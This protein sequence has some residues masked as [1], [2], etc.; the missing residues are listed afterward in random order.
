MTPV[1]ALPDSSRCPRQHPGA[2]LVGLLTPGARVGGHF[3]IASARTPV[4][5]LHHE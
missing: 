2:G 4:E 1:A 5:A 3:G